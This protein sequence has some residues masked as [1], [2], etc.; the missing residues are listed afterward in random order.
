MIKELGNFPISRVCIVFF[1]GLISMAG[2][3][4]AD[5]INSVDTEARGPRNVILIVGD[6]MDDHQITIARNYLVGARGRLSMDELPV[7]GQVQVLTISEEDPSLPV[8]VADSANSATSMST[9]VVTSRGRLATTAKTD[10]DLTTIVEMAEA[11]GIRTGLVA[12]ASV[13]DATPAAFVAHTRFRFCEDPA[14]MVEIEYS[15][16]KMEACPA[17]LI[18][19]G[20]LGS[21]SEQIAASDLEVVL[22]GGAQHF[23]PMNESGTMT[24]REQAEANGFYVVTTREELGNAPVDKKLLGLF[25]ESTLP[26]RLR[27]EGG[28]AAEM[29]TPSFLNRIHWYLGSVELPEVMECESNPEF[30]G[31]PTL[32]EMTEVALK[33]LSYENERGFFLMVESASIDKEAHRR[34]A[35]GSVGEVEQLNEALDS[36]LKFSETH[37]DTLIIVTADHGHAA[38]LVPDESLFS[39]TG[40]A[41][42]TPGHLVRLR[43]ADG[44][45]IAVN[46][47]TTDF[48]AEEHTG[49]QVPILANGVG[50]G[51]V[52]V[53]LHQTEIFSIMVDYLGLERAETAA[54]NP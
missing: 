3:L 47:A 10:Q 9:G 32:K 38:Q 1:L 11:A 39:K 35:C 53:M 2:A 15:G 4:Q 45:N 33:Q 20:G 23:E 31:T 28:R 14:N 8:F 27:G 41:V 37:P 26:P 5:G 18:S 51:R 7:R 16:I 44:A 13:T 22:G 52:P 21:V 50:F 19:N 43:G 46:Y 42:F 34:Q 48:F 54:A 24:V 29:P 40:I 49:V 6:G 36:A 25:A 30:S 12:T 17:D